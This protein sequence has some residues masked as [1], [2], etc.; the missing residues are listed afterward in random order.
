MMLPDATETLAVFDL[1]RA[2]RT[3]TQIATELATRGYTLFPT[4][5]DVCCVHDHTGHAIYVGNSG[6]FFP[7]LIERLGMPPEYLIPLK[8]RKVKTDQVTFGQQMMD[9]ALA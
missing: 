1:I 7:F 9:T 4:E 3:W 6:H 2:A 8:Y 5:E